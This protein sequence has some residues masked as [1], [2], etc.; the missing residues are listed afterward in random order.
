MPN[1]TPATD[2]VKIVEGLD[3]EAIREQLADLDRQADSLRVLPRA[4]LARRRP[5]YTPP[6][7]AAHV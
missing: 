7:E 6:K 3:P 4:V 2:A 5:H 1:T